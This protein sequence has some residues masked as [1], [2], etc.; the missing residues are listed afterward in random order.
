MMSEYMDMHTSKENNKSSKSKFPHLTEKEV[1]DVLAQLELQ[2][3]RLR[4]M[5]SGE[6][7][8]KRQPQEIFRVL[9]ALY[10]K[11]EQEDLV[12]QVD[13]DKFP[14][15]HVHSVQ[16]TLVGNDGSNYNVFMGIYPE[17]GHFS[18]NKDKIGATYNNF[19]FEEHE[20]KKQKIFL[21]MLVLQVQEGL[22]QHC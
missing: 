14:N 3:D 12:L 2:L 1:K 11:K 8:T 22:L 9:W 20:H 15:I 5:Q 17:L 10:Q 21:R 7:T 18:K 6:H 16:K 19:F 13:F 4:D